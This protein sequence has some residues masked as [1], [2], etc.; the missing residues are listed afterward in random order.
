MGK[1]KKVV[2][3]LTTC[4]YLENLRLAIEVLTGK[5]TN[6]VRFDLNCGRG[7]VRVG[8]DLVDVTCIALNLL[9]IK[10]RIGLKLRPGMNP[11]DWFDANFVDGVARVTNGTHYCTVLFVG[12][13]M[14]DRWE[15]YNCL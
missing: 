10:F 13:S 7:Q 4:G 11:A 12:S 3:T 14:V 15:E 1:A 5:R 9:E 6:Y 8:D 2:L